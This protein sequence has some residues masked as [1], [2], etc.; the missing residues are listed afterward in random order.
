MLCVEVNSSGALVLGAALAR[1][2]EIDA[3]GGQH[4]PEGVVDEVEI[5]EVVRVVRTKDR[6][7]DSK[8]NTMGIICIFMKIIQEKQKSQAKDSAARLILPP[9]QRPAN[10]LVFR[11]D[12]HDAT[13]ST[14]AVTVHAA[15]E[16]LRNDLE[17]V[18]RLLRHK[19]ETRDQ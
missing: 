16:A 9:L 4:S 1:A 15:E 2:L 13:P 6:R 11:Y 7:H 5:L 3:R 17:Q 14:E 8:G 18:L 19:R 12:I 10:D